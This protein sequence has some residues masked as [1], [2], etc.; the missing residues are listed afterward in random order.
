MMINLTKIS[1]HNSFMKAV[2][3]AVLLPVS[4]FAQNQGAQSSAAGDVLGSGNYIHI[5]EDL[6]RTLAFYQELLGAEPNG[7]TEPRAFG[8]LEPV[9]Q[10]YNAVG[11]E[12][13]G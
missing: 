11:T 9:L 12:F 5:V 2:L 7:G 10:M 8:A 1:I 3:F 13:R 4:V 6:D